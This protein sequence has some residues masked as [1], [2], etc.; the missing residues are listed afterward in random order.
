MQPKNILILEDEPIVSEFIARS[1]HQRG[2]ANIRTVSEF[3]DASRV[4]EQWNAQILILNLKLLDGWIST[5][6]LEGLLAQNVKKIVIASGG[7][8]SDIPDYLCIDNRTSLLP[9]P[10]TAHQLISM[11]E[12]DL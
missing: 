12:N 7:R 9:K 2:N 4:T 3:A 1:I 5:K 6:W 10:F 8:S 11:L